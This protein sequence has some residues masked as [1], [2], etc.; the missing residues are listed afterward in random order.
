ML[1][2]QRLARYQQHAE[3]R[4]LARKIVA[5]VH[6]EGSAEGWRASSRRSAA[7]SLGSAIDPN[8]AGRVERLRQQLRQRAWQ[9]G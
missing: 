4:V 5:E 7:P 2:E 3:Q 9:L 6:E 8:I 1:E